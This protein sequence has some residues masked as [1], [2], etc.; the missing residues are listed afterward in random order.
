VIDQLRQEVRRPAGAVVA[1]AAICLV[2]GT[3]CGRRLPQRPS[4]LLL[5]VDTL[6]AD[7]LG[8]YGYPRATSPVL[9]QMA[10][11]SVRFDL[12]QSQW[13]K[14]GPSFASLLTATYPKDNGIVREIGKP[15][16]CG[17][18]TLA[19][20]LRDLGYQTGAV[21]A[22]GAVGSDFFYDQGFEH[23]VEAWKGATSEAEIEEAT[24]AGP[25]RT[26]RIVRPRR[27]GTSSRRTVGSPPAPRSRSTASITVGSPAASGDP[28]SWTSAPTWTSTSPA[29][30]PR[31]PTPTPRSGDWST[32]CAGA[33]STTGF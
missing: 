2:L 5:T 6:R 1:L 25:I 7:H 21:V 22:N 32:I 26:F 15:L 28:R 13:P 30:T 8:A 16:P 18:R 10:S 3:G 31:S 12:A 29:T 19:E 9:D 17:F 27:G 23:F 14:T 24:R 20:E 11:E 33:S 4:V